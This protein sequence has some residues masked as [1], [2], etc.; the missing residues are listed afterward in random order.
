MRSD[1][2]TALERHGF[3]VDVREP[4]SFYLSCVQLV[5]REGN[6]F[7]GVADPRRDGEAGGPTK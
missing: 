3:S 1:I 7:I 5:M 6:K 2:P 4:Y